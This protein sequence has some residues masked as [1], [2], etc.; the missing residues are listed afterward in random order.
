M[1]PCC[2]PLSTLYPSAPHSTS[3]HTDTHKTCIYRSPPTGSLTG[4]WPL[5]PILHNEQ[6]HHCLLALIPSVPSCPLRL[7]T[8]LPS[9]P[10]LR[11][12]SEDCLLSSCLRHGA[13]LGKLGHTGR[14]PWC[15]ATAWREELPVPANPLLAPPPKQSPPENT[16]P[17][18]LLKTADFH[19]YYTYKA[20]H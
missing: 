16:A 9:L 3:T 20:D 1:G 12:S 5:E 13:G 14:A 6:P 7:S 19:W 11:C 2:L 18:K 4:G 17:I 10:T 8:F 15:P